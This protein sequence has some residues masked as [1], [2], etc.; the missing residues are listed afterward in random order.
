MCKQS[1]NNLYLSLKFCIQNLQNWLRLTIPTDYDV[2][3]LSYPLE[4]RVRR[5]IAVV[6][7]YQVHPDHETKHQLQQR[8]QRVRLPRFLHR[9]EGI[10]TQC[11]QQHCVRNC[12]CG[13]AQ[14][15]KKTT[16]YVGSCEGAGISV[17][18]S[19]L[20]A[21]SKGSYGGECSFVTRELGLQ[22]RLLQ[23]HSTHRA[24]P[25]SNTHDACQI[26]SEQSPQVNMPTDKD[27]ALWRYQI[28]LIGSRDTKMPHCTML[29]A[30]QRGAAHSSISGLFFLLA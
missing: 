6:C 13:D 8:Q 4:E 12:G 17:L 1:A 7:L 25:Q 2:D 10:P 29:L 5:R 19:D 16:A 20:V 9:D 24:K 30:E 11:D 22:Q 3:E 15:G 18:H 14:K 26:Q 27:E 23:K 28:A 21:F